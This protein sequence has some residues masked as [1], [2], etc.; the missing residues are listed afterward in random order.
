MMNFSSGIGSSHN[1]RTFAE[2]VSE[3]LIFNSNSGE[4]VFPKLTEEMIE[5]NAAEAA[6]EDRAF[7]GVPAE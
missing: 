2:C 6:E 7:F 3:A 4:G 1:S 5:Q